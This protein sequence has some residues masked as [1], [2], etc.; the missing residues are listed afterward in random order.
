MLRHVSLLAPSCVASGTC[1]V[2]V[3]LLGR[4]LRSKGFKVWV[5]Q[6]VG[7]G[8]EWFKQ[9]RHSFL[10][11]EGDPAFPDQLYVVDPNFRDQFTIAR[12]T[13]HYSKVFEA[14]PRVFLGRG[15]RLLSVIQLLSAEIAD[16]FTQLGLE[17]PPWRKKK[18]MLSKW[19]P[20]RKRDYIPAMFVAEEEASHE[21]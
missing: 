14:V 12:T 10:L 17:T 4:K 8:T 1:V 15:K 16:A 21:Q 3:D 2:D 7:G 9:L 6:A 13:A 5:R 19:M 18:P 11:V 20:E